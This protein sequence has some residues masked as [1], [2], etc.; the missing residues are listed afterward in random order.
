MTTHD[1]IDG[2]KHNKSRCK[3]KKEARK[4]LNDFDSHQNRTRGG[5][6]DW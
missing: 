5:F 6:D 2:Q 4:Q 1:K 3:N